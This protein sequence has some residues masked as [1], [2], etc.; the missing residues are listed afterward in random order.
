M[1]RNDA[2]DRKRKRILNDDEIRALWKADGMFGAIVK[3][4]LL[5]AQRRDKVKTMKWADISGGYLDNRN[6]SPRES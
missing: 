3:V 1:G 5:T 4:L 2:G 6:R